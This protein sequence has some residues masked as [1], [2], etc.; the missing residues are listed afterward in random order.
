MGCN[1]PNV[2]YRLPVKK[3]KKDGTLGENI[4][5]SP[6]KVK[7]YDRFYGGG[8]ADYGFLDGSLSK[9]S[10][11][12]EHYIAPDFIETIGGITCVRELVNCGN[13]LSCRLQY[14]KEWANRIVLESMLYPRE[15]CWFVTLTYDP[16]E[17]SIENGTLNQWDLMILNKDHCVKFKKDLRAYWQYHYNHTGIREFT[18]G[19]YGDKSDR[20]HYH[21]CLFNIDIPD[22]KFFGTNFRG[23]IF[24]TSEILTSI[25]GRGHVIVSELNWAT[26]A[27]T[28]RYVLK[29][30]RD[31]DDKKFHQNFDIPLPFT[32]KS[33]RPGLAHDI[34]EKSFD[35]IYEKDTIVLPSFGGKE[36]VVKP[37]KYFDM[38][39]Q[40]VNPEHYEQ[41]KEHRKY[42]AEIAA[43]RIKKSHNYSEE[44]FFDI[45]AANLQERVKKLK[46]EL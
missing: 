20:P 21:L 3:F 22:L 13:C 27:Y 29:K 41:V 6:Y 18:A 7:N 10:E 8:I 11:D 12:G 23:D 34:F 16:S 33:N 2:I 1:S 24:Y 44:Q 43:D 31:M 32:T 19:E 36:K 35:Q 9:R 37:P 14:S 45:Q 40:R 28:A 17:I 25:W 38:L 4:M 26:A 39:Y 30:A 46:R 42:I 5:F 15:R